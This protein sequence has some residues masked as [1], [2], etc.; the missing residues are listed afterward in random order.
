MALI[1]YK[2]NQGIQWVAGSAEKEKIMY[3]PF[4]FLGDFFL[5]QSKYSDSYKLY[6]VTKIP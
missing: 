6:N 4:I 2:I 1:R 5:S 3:L